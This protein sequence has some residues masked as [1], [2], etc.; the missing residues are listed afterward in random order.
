MRIAVNASFFKNDHSGNDINFFFD[1]F[2]RLSQFHTEHIFIFIF[3][4]PYLS[5][6]V[7]PE[8]VIPVVIGPET[9]NSLTWRIW[10]NFKI[11]LVLKKYKADIFIT[12][13]F[14]STRTSVPQ[15]LIYPDLNFIHQPALVNKRHLHFYKKHSS[16]FL[17]KCDAIV[18]DSTFSKNDLV[19]RYQIAEQKISVFFPNVDEGFRPLNYEEKEIIKEKYAEGHEYFIYNG[20]ISP[21]QNL[22]NLLKAFSAFKKR[23]KS[24][25]QLLIVGEPGIEYEEWVA[26]LKLYRFH[27]EVKV[28][29]YVSQ[30]EIKKIVASAYAMVYTPF[31]ETSYKMP[32]QAMACKV[33]LVVSDAGV[34]REACA[35][36]ALYADPNDFKSIAEKMMLVFKDERLRKELIEKGVTQ[37]KNI[38]ATRLPINSFHGFDFF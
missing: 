17:N 18:V 32:L 11:P 3:D 29:H 28:L 1:F 15:L 12:E 36:A 2:L 26:A 37:L 13:K 21:H 14:C 35:E 20:I 5:S 10:Y 7:F 24:S 22:K 16:R 34:L 27:E 4:K 8:N 33:P 9:R 31:Y 19:H 25:M 23:Q 38:A 6:L 30:N